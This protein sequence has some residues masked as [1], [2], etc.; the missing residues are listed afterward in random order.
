MPK[1][2][3]MSIS[4]RRKVGESKARGRMFRLSPPNPAATVAEDQ[5]DLL[6][7]LGTS[8]METRT[9]KR[10]DIRAFLRPVANEPSRLRKGVHVLC[11]WEDGMLYNAMVVRPAGKNFV[12]LVFDS[13]THVECVRYRGAP[14]TL[15]NRP[16]RMYYNA[17]GFRGPF[18][19]PQ[20]RIQTRKIPKILSYILE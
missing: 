8:R 7:T 6:L 10:P 5:I 4:P 12:R 17:I 19:V 18:A 15:K 1:Q 16:R 2:P 9:S 11:E 3:R 13:N 14:C 20:A